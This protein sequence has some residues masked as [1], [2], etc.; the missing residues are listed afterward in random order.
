MLKYLT[1]LVGSDSI[2]KSEESSVNGHDKKSGGLQVGVFKGNPTPIKFLV[3]EFVDHF[4]QLLKV[5]FWIIPLHPVASF[6]D[7][8]FV[9]V[10]H[11]S[12]IIAA[13]GGDLIESP[14][15]VDPE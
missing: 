11:E 6:K 5:K 4:V 9:H 14:C 8:L 2:F 13:A 7:F 12:G 15:V 1:N 10:L 3:V